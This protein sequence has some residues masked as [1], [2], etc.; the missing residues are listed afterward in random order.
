[1]TK[2]EFLELIE[3]RI[4]FMDGATGS[5]LQKRGMPVG[6]C[7]ED[8]ILNNKQTLIDLQCEF[9]EAGSDIILAPTFTANRI[10]LAEYGFENQIAEINKGLIGVSKKAVDNYYAKSEKH[11]KVFI[12]GDLTMTGEQVQPVGNLPFEELVDVYKEQLRYILAEGVDLIVVETMMSL[13]ECRAAL[14]AVKESCDLPVIVSLTFAE[15]GR[16]LFGT[17]P[18]TAVIVL[19][20]IGAD[21]IGVNCSTGP[22]KMIEIIKQM[23][24]YAYIPIMAK[25]NAGLPELVDGKTVFPMEAQEFAEEVA[26]LVEAGASIVGGCCGS[27][28]KHIE[29]LVKQAIDL[30]PPRVNENHTRVLTTETDSVEIPLDGRFMIVGERINPTGKKALQAQL[31]EGELDIV[32]QMAE[33]QAELGAAILDINV[34][35]NGIDEKEMMLEVMQEALRASKLPLCIDSSHVPVVEAALRLYPGRALINS[36]SLE[37][38]KFE[39]LIP[40]AKKYGAMF[41]L[42]PLSDKGLPKDIEEKKQIIHTILNRA[43]ELGL[44]KEDVIVDGLVNTVGANKMA[45]I[46][47]LQTIRYCKEE[48]GVATIVGLSNISFGLPERQ[49]VNSTFLSFAI[50]TGLT[51]AIANPSQDLLVNTA[52]AADLLRGIEDAAEAYIERVTTRPTTITTSTASPDVKPGAKLLG[53]VQVKDTCCTPAAGHNHGVKS[54]Q[55]VGVAADNKQAIFE[56]VVKGNRKNIIALVEK[57]LESGSE[58]DALIEQVLIPAINEVGSLYDKQIYFLPQLISGAETMKTA[59][60]YLE[61]KLKKEEG[62]SKGTIVIATVA[63]DIHDIGKNLVT[64]MLKNYG[65]RVIDLGKDVP[66]EKIIQ[67]AKEENADIIAL[68]A[69]MTTTMVEMKH[70]IE[71]AKEAKL[72]AKIMIGGAVITE[73]YA[74]EIGADGYSEDAQSAVAMVQRFL[75]KQE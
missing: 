20:N 63:G 32:N 70:V 56:A 48:L 22:D 50:Q 16:T 8:W 37:K 3:S 66:S 55:T 4:V 41:I 52:L 2:K 40:I 39:K 18:K 71:L 34:G 17:D 14:L 68:S 54:E 30:Q 62:S 26:K 15:N 47:A 49:Y 29:L 73:S 57:E 65:F 74:D 51:M 60:D 43:F 19:Q 42:L 69:L 28:P 44:T 53:S 6:V 24:E 59:I 67:T 46:E 75:G 58:P 1:M 13:Q 36:I 64:L 33:E 31:K 21:A 27:T 12:A 35:M 5:N 23:K 11:R 25:P 61:P 45:S 38:E 9:L 72:R 10:K 7:P